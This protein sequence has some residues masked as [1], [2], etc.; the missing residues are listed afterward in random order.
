MFS[1]LRCLAY[2]LG[3]HNAPLTV[4]NASRTL[5]S[6]RLLTLAIYSRMRRSAAD[7]IQCHMKRCK[8]LLPLDVVWSESY[9]SMEHSYCLCCCWCWYNRGSSRPVTEH[10]QTQMHI[11]FNGTHTTCDTRTKGTKKKHIFLLSIIRCMHFV[12]ITCTAHLSERSVQDTY[13]TRHVS[14]CFISMQ[15][16]TCFSW[17]TSIILK[18]RHFFLHLF[19][20]CRYCCCS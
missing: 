1:I 5:D 3:K 16:S 2:L 4:G 20:Q 8:G 10:T 15:S 6:V 13:F 9:V 17:K 18:L 19:C 11:D 14:V 7:F 12:R